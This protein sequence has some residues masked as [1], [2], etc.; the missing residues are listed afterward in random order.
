MMGRAGRIQFDNVGVACILVH[1]PKKNFYR[2]FLYEPFPVESQLQ[3]A[4]P[5]HI[6]AEIAG[7]TIRSREDAVDWL[8][9][10]F[11]FRR[12]VRNPT[13]YNLLDTTPEGVT[14]HL[15]NLVD[16][17]LNQ[18]KRN[19]CCTLG[20][21]SN[22]EEEQEEERELVGRLGSV[23]RDRV[24]P[25]TLGLIASYYYI[26]SKTVGLFDRCIDEVE[27]VPDLLKLLS[28]AF[29]YEE[30]P[31]R[32]NEDTVNAELAKV[33]P[34][35]VD[36]YTMDSPHTKTF[37]LLQARMK[38]VKLPLADYANDLKSVLDQALRILNALVDVAADAGLLEPVLIAMETTQL[39]VQ[40]RLPSDSP[41]LQLPHVNTQVVKMFNA[42]GI[43]TL[44]QL[45]PSIVRRVFASSSSSSNQSNR[46]VRDVMEASKCIPV[47]D[48]K[49][50]LKNG[51][52]KDHVLVL[53][54]ETEYDLQVKLRLES[55][56][57]H[58]SVLTK[59]FPKRKSCG[60]WLVIG[61]ED[62]LLAL[63]RLHS[64]GSKGSTTSLTFETPDVTGTQR[65]NLKLFLIADSIMGV[66]QEYEID[67]EVSE[68]RFDGDNGNGHIGDD[69]D[70]DD[71]DDDEDE[72]GFWDN[73]EG[74]EAEEEEG[75][76]D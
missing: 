7:G 60:W 33:L 45:E 4:L 52:V 65:F 28:D 74:S 69:D 70:D 44:P 19:G 17:V 76:W 46:V 57:T 16:G 42:N 2:K 36:D 30:L 68:E 1:Q 20:D 37:L 27:S 58:P 62:E 21:G 13:Y 39:I 8:T 47:V 12:L 41:L 64:I 50:S 11:F 63:K 15:K 59:S 56:T 72:D 71:G 48:V 34:F 5:E 55:G 35:E 43:T 75:F 73:N 3:D 18:L 31:V 9:W 14:T 40:G 26:S 32:H 66:D 54:R 6:N 23:K 53:E 22:G 25:T 29:E 49:W 38:R 24:R 67:F 61:Y 10:T 51:H